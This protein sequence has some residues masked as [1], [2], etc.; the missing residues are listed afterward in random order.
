LQILEAYGKQFKTLPQDK[1][2]AQM[3]WAFNLGSDCGHVEPVEV[4][5]DSIQYFRY[6]SFIISTYKSVVVSCLLH[7]NEPVLNQPINAVF[8]S[9]DIS[10]GY[11]N[12]QR[13]RF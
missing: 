13:R 4:E 6:S 1:T 7:L 2:H 11:E 10:P 5:I 12:V 8:E 9:K 3:T